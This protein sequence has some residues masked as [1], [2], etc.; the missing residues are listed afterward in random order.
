M[1]KE[2]LI[3]DPPR[4]GEWETV[5]SN[6]FGINLSPPGG[7]EL[8]TPEEL[9]EL[10]A[11]IVDVTSFPEDEVPAAAPA[12]SDQDEVLPQESSAESPQVAARG[13]EAAPDEPPAATIA[14]EPETAAVSGEAPSPE[15]GEPEDSYWDPLQAWQWD[16]DEAAQPSK[17][18]RGEAGRTAEKPAAENVV[19]GPGADARRAAESFETVSD[20]RSE[21]EQESS[22]DWAFGAGLLEDVPAPEE[23]PKPPPRRESPQPEAR[24]EKTPEPPEPPRREER[25]PVAAERPPRKS[26]PRGPAGPAGDD[27]FAAGLIEPAAEPE[28]PERKAA[29]DEAAEGEPAA[30]RRPRRKRRRKPAEERTGEDR[31]PADDWPELEDLDETGEPEEAQEEQEARGGPKESRP[32]KDRYR[33]IPTWETAISYLLKTRRAGERDSK[34]GPSAEQS[35]SSRS[36]SDRPNRGGRRRRRRPRKP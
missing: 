3:P 8:V 12:E 19:K 23:E 36:D 27:D 6:L 25:K 33:N 14:R 29:E 22:E 20:Y 26:E 15:P 7:E 32:K 11:E 31:P 35:P 4:G 17:S 2:P 18:A 24:R 9:D 10:D 1:H 30:Q 16:E 5:A 28:A 13:S 34:P 21:Y